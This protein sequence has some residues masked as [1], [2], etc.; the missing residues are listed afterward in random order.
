MGM[1]DNINI[2][3]AYLKGLIDKKYEKLLNNSTEYQTKS[4][5][6]TLQT[7]K[8]HRKQLYIKTLVKKTQSWEKVDFTGDVDFYALVQD[9]A[10]TD[11]TF[12]FKFGFIKGKLD[13]KEL[14]LQGVGL[15]LEEKKEL[16]QQREAEQA[17]FDTF[18]STFKWRFFNKLENAF[19]KCTEF[20]AARTSISKE[21]RDQA[22]RIAKKK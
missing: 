3:V 10:K 11:Y 21:L 22:Y 5:E 16:D 17:V 15:T 4:L 2:P 18:R 7:Y 13:T 20:C 9:A 12:D 8:V 19:K 1:F 14:T 6:N